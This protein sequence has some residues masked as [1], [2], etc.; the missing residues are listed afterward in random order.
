MILRKRQIMVLLTA[1]L[2][3]I[4][5]MGASRSNLN[6]EQAS[7]LTLRIQNIPRQKTTEPLTIFWAKAGD[8]LYKTVVNGDKKK[9]YS[10]LK[11][12]FSNVLY[13]DYETV[14]FLKQG[15]GQAGGIY[16]FTMSS[17][18]LTRLTNLGEIDQFFLKN[19]SIYYTTNS[20][21]IDRGVYRMSLDGRSKKRVSPT[22]LD[23]QDK[24][25][26][27]YI[28]YGIQ[29]LGDLYFPLM[30]QPLPSTGEMYIEENVDDET[31]FD[32][33]FKKTKEEQL[34][35]YS[36]FMTDYIGEADSDSF[37][38]VER[39]RDKH[40]TYLHLFQKGDEIVRKIIG[41]DLE[42]LDVLDGWAYFTVSDEDKET[43]GVFAIR[44]DGS[45]L[46]QVGGNEFFYSD[47]LGSIKRH[48]VFQNRNDDSFATLKGI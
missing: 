46:R 9:T 20:M 2:I 3:C 47:Y 26:H 48:L 27:Y 23:P 37:F 22:V 36:F 12:N 10:I 30:R 11:G 31:A 4:P 1:V 35:S 44:M 25:Y 32:R 18:K 45:G 14:Y 15:E 28:G 39:D 38:F 24:K 33:I 42:P 21:T 40:T 43:G 16:K 7:E 6:L 19:Q 29:T 41:W 17:K 5:L 8:G 34:S 13:Q